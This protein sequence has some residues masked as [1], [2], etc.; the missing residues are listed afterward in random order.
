MYA[1]YAMETFLQSLNFNVEMYASCWI[2]A[3]TVPGFKY[4]QL[5]S[6]IEATIIF[7]ILSN[8]MHVH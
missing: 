1:A 2:A 8:C 7:R 4:F 3:I 5:L 6:S